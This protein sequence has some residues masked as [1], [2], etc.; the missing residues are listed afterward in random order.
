MTYDLTSQTS[1][2]GAGAMDNNWSVQDA[3]AR[4]SEVL[5]AAETATQTITYRGVPKFEIRLIRKSK[6]KAKKGLPRWWTEAPKV[7]LELP[8]RRAEPMR[9]IEF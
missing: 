9:K 4:F 8:E 2:N 7:N 3:K 1:Q 6:K 5:R